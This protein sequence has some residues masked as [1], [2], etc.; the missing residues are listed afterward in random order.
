MWPGEVKHHLA[1]LTDRGIGAF[2]YLLATPHGRH[3]GRSG[4]DGYSAFFPFKKNERE[5]EG[6]IAST[7]RILMDVV[8]AHMPKHGIAGEEREGVRPA[9]DQAVDVMAPTNR[10]NIQ[11]PKASVR[12][13]KKRRDCIWASKRLSE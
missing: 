5:E 4:G 8:I 10:L 11:V 12:P 3:T 2:T 9:D 6:Q 13:G 1:I 7:H